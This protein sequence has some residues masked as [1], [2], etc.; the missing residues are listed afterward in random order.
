MTATLPPDTTTLTEQSSRRFSVKTAQSFLIKRSMLLIMILVVV[1]FSA[2]NARFGTLDN[3]QSIL[4]AAAPFALIAFGQTLVILTGGIDLS[5]GSTIAL[6]AMVAAWMA[7]ANPDQLGLAFA[8]AIATGVVVGLANGA[9]VAFLHVPP[10]IATLALLTT[11]S[12]LAYVI[13]NGAPINGLPPA[14]GD[15][16]MVR[17]V[18][19]NLI[20]NAFKFTRPKSN[21]T[22]E[23]GFQAGGNQNT[24]FVRD[25]GVGFDMQYSQKLFGVFQRLHSVDDYEGSGVGLALVQRI[26]LRHGGRVWAEGKMDEGATLYFSLPKA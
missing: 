1:Y 24:Y 15:R 26:V 18:L 4:L 2:T 10:F 17:Q 20:S 25:N 14:F 22:I 6:S 12:G 3:L 8:A 19:Y 13:G 11:A 23:I 5:V 21:P 7:Q 9:L 16:A